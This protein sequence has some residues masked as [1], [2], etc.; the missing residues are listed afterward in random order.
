MILLQLSNEKC[1]EYFYAY[2]DLLNTHTHT[3]QGDAYVTNHAVRVASGG[4][5]GAVPPELT[6]R[7][8]TLTF[9]AK[10]QENE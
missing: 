2:Y 3:L 4:V 1:D 5:V 10:Y 6:S 9:C 8:H 7:T